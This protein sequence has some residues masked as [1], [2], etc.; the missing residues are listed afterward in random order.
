MFVLYSSI[1]NK[2]GITANANII[3]G[4]IH[5]VSQRKS[6]MPDWIVAMPTICK[7]LKKRAG[8]LTMG[9]KIKP[10]SNRLSKVEPSSTLRISAKAREL[11][12][13]GFDVVD[14]S[15]GEPGLVLK[16]EIKDAGKKA[17][18]EN[19]NKYTPVS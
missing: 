17:I 13:E 8:S 1:A 11:K 12:K 14:F 4:F 3:A 9:V 15:V 10:L 7:S 5:V 16:S 2:I 19:Q 6:I 18:D